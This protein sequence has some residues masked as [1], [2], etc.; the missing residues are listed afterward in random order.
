MR[1]LESKAREGWRQVVESQG[2]LF[3][4]NC[5][6]T[7]YWDERVCFEFSIAEIQ[8]L[9]DAANELHGMFL[10]ACG[11]AITQ[12]RLAEFGIPKDC[13]RSFVNRG[14][15]MIGNFTGGLI[16]LWMR[17]EHRSYWSTTRILRR[18]CWRPV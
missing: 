10:R 13:M 6:G 5:D 9:E 3:H 1:R 12:R 8:N 2:L 16:L 18:G 17:R 4:S 14:D 11:V 15:M 7:P